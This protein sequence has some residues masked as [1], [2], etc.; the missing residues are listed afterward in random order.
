MNSSTITKPGFSIVGISVRTT[1]ENNQAM[2]DI[3]QLWGR[4]MS[5]NIGEQIPNKVSEDVYCMYT[6]YE[7]DVN[8][9][10]TTILGYQVS[11]LNDVPNGMQGKAVPVAKYQVFPAKG[12]LPDIVVDT[13]K[14]IWGSPEIE[15]A[16]VADFEV[17][18]AGEE[19]SEESEVETYVSVR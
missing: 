7:S 16:Y 6:D 10:Y 11:S 17:Y 13:W 1:N 4:F 19:D 15:R 8:A 12:K 2:Q 14:Q 5:E 18:K 3:G 9:P